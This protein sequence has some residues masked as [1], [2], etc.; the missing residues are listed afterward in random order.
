MTTNEISESRRQLKLSLQGS[1]Q[2]DCKENYI[3]TPIGTI[4]WEAEN[5]KLQL[6]M[7]RFAQAIIAD[8]GGHTE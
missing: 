3:I 6:I 4:R 8:Y 2:E 5:L 1:F 7:E